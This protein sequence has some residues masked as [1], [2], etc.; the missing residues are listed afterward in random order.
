[1]SNLPKQFIQDLKSQGLS[2]STVYNY[3]SDIRRFLEWH[4][5]YHG[6]PPKIYHK[7]SEN[8]NR[9][10][11]QLLKDGAGVNTVTRY[12]TS[13]NRYVDWLEDKKYFQDLVVT[14]KKITNPDIAKYTHT[15]TKKLS[16]FYPSILILVPSLPF[17]EGHNKDNF[18][19][20]FYRGQY[21]FFPQ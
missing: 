19:F 7:L 5:E 4:K 14:E 15:L 20:Q 8:I 3:R 16:N 17:L 11:K 18:Y 12:L 13:L 10:Q 21:D 1:M 6:D 9:Y 2:Q